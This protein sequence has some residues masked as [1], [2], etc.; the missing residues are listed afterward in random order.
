MIQ[1]IA[2]PCS[3]HDE[4]IGFSMNSPSAEDVGASDLKKDNL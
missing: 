2:L 3:G 4:E 1:K